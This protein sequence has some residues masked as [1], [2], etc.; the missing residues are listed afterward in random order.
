MPKCMGYSK[1]MSK[2]EIHSN[3]CLPRITRTFTNKQ[4][5]FTIQETR[6]GGT[7]PKVHTMKYVTKIR[8]EINVIETENTIEKVNKT[9]RWF[10]KKVNKMA[11]L[12]LGSPRKKEQTQIKSDMKEEM[13]Q[14]LPQKYKGS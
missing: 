14:L 4:L 6:R 3:K 13:L 9:K 1:R 12:W 10:F 7:K 5:K 2:R 8:G 11:I